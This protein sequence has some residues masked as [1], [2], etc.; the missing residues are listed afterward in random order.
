MPYQFHHTSNHLSL[1]SLYS[2]SA[3]YTPN[4]WFK[5]RQ[6]SGISKSYSDSSTYTQETPAQHVQTCCRVS[7]EEAHL[8]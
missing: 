6:L 3:N 5:R 1:F 2:A 8:M 4:Y 7:I